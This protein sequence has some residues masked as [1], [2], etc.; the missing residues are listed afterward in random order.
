MYR[1]ALLLTG[2]ESAAQDLLHDAC[3][4]CAS[5]LAGI[6]IEEARMA[7]MVVHMR[8]KAKPAAQAGP[9]SA[10]AGR[11][12]AAAFAA[13]PEEERVALAGLYTGL[14]PARTLAEALKISLEQLG[15]R[16]KSA[17]EA[18]ARG[19]V[20]LGEPSLEQAL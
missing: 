5:R 20:E 11:G 4:D 3:A 2:E 10:G 13:L 8:Q 17:R 6:R 14:L 16:L 7:C 9:A 1:F 12:I 15:R 18:L 19:G